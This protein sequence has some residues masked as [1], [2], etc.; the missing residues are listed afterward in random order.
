MKIFWKVLAAVFL[1]LPAANIYADGLIGS[2]AHYAV[3]HMAKNAD[4]AH[5]GAAFGKDDSL[6]GDPSAIQSKPICT[7]QYFNG[8]AP[9][10]LNRKLAIKIKLGCFDHFT[11]MHSGLTRTPLWSAE[12][13][14]G[15][16]IIAASRLQRENPFHPEER[17]PASERAELSDYSRSGFDRGHMSP[18]KDM[19]SKLA[20]WQCFTLANMIPQNPNNNQVL[21]EGIESA[22][23]ALTKKSGELYVITGPLYLGDRIQS[24]Y[25]RVMVPTQIFK[26][27]LDPRSGQAAAYLADNTEGMGYKVISIAGL[28]RI[29][30]ID[31]FPSLSARAKEA[32]MD[33]PKPTPHRHESN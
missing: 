3:Q 24:L 27:V 19:P 16:N 8:A 4:T 6:F 14:T 9:V 12:H 5:G 21:W 13:L 28:E 31:F 29:S 30:G 26:A 20:Q 7:A 33:L 10:I 1:C 32:A 17:L 25:G 22:V 11:V 23:R 15:E 18:N 2:F